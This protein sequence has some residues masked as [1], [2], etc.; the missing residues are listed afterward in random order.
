MYTIIFVDNG[1]KYSC[2]YQLSRNNLKEAPCGL[3]HIARFETAFSP[4][5]GLGYYGDIYMHQ[6]IRK[7]KKY[8][9]RQIEKKITLLCIIKKN[10][11]NIDTLRYI[12]KYI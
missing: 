3:I 9:K 8:K 6:F 10:L 11:L 2:G 12:L 1:P 5:I 7:W 4:D